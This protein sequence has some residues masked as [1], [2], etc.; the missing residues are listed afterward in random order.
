M[1]TRLF[2][3]NFY[4]ESGDICLSILKQSAS[5]DGWM[6]SMSIA[7]VRVRLGVPVCL[8][9]F[10]M[11][12]RQVCVDAKSDAHTPSFSLCV[13]SGC[14]S[15]LL[16]PASPTAPPTTRRCCPPPSQVLLSIRLLIVEPNPA[17]AANTQAGQLVR[18]PIPHTCITDGGTRPFC[19]STLTPPRSYV[20]CGGMFFCVCM[21][22]A[23]SDCNS[24]TAGARRSTTA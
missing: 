22:H 4:A 7:T 9:V 16:I 15:M 3:P 1:K 17:D 21:P 12:M 10:R 20:V 6:P 8:Y 2:H 13:R 14:L 19:A 23:S 5:G 24:C 18:P 11:H